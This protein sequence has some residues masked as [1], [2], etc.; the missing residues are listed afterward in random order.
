MDAHDIKKI[1]HQIKYYNITS[2]PAEQMC[3]SADFG[4]FRSLGVFRSF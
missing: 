2:I 1:N 3:F 4:V